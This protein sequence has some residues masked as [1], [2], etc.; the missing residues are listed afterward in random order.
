MDTRQQLRIAI[1]EFLQRPPEDITGNLSLSF[2]MGSIG[3]ARLAAAIQ[4]RIGVVCPQVYTAKTYGELESA[5]LKQPQHISDRPVAGNGTAQPMPVQPFAAL[6]GEVACGID[7]EMVDSLPAHPDY[8]ES[9]F[10]RASFSPAEIAFCNSQE[11]PRLHFAARWAAKEA[12]KKCDAEFMS[13]D[14]NHL[15]VLHNEKSK[16]S[17][18]LLAGGEKISLP[19]AVSLTH[20]SLLAAAIVVKL[21]S[22]LAV[23]TA[24]ATTPAN[25]LHSTPGHP[26]FPATT[27]QSKPRLLARLLGKK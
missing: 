9:D 25:A 15:E 20:T 24:P 13:V 5:I 23:E 21:G 10:Y 2:A 7:I 16:P 14:M 6:A 27:T 11:N 17:L 22:T 12:L 3:R 1:A 8:W 4:R 26:T 19:F 18:A